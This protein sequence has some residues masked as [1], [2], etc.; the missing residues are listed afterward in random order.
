MLKARQER[1]ASQLDA[2][3]DHLARID[4]SFKKTVL[5]QVKAGERIPCTT[6]DSRTDESEDVMTESG[7]D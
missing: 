4:P 6:L 5:P 3:E 2:I 1:M 7:E